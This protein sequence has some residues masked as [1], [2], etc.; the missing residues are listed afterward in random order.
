MTRKNE[1]SKFACLIFLN[2]SVLACSEA[3]FRGVSDSDPLVV[4]KGATVTRDFQIREPFSNKAD[5]LF[6]VDASGSME[7]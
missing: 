4:P 2:L 5:I 6:L 1:M 7:R 3:E